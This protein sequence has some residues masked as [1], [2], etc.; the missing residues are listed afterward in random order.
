MS[1]LELTNSTRDRPVGSG[2]PSNAVLVSIGMAAAIAFTWLVVVLP[3]GNHFL[4]TFWPIGVALDS[5]FVI[6]VLLVWDAY[7]RSVSLSAEG[8][9]MKHIFGTTR[10]AWS[11]VQ[12]PTFLDGRSVVF[13]T[14]DSAPGYRGAAMRVDKASAKQILRSPL[15]PPWPVPPE[16]QSFLD[17]P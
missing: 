3:R 6:I 5:V 1:T 10:V 9:V 13:G 15:R 14:S 12:P 11:D 8:V 4:L 17:E 2:I 16:F 7:P